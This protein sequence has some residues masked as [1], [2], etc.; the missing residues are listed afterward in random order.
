MNIKRQE[1]F[2]IMA[3]LGPLALI[4]GYIRYSVRETMGPLNLSLLSY[5]EAVKWISQRASRS[6]A[7]GND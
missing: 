5:N 1:V 4:A 2:K 6:L 7:Q 3:F